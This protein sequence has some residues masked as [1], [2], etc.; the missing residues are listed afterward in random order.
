MEKCA[1][2]IS[3]Y[4]WPEALELCLK[5]VIQQTILPDE[6]LIADDGSTDSTK[7][8][9]ESFV[10]LGIVN[11]K[12]VWHE[13]VGFRKTIILNKAISMI[14]SDY[15]IQIDGDVILDRNFIK[16]HLFVR[17]KGCFIRGTRAHIHKDSLKRLFKNKEISL[18]FYSRG[19]QNRFNALRVSFLAFLMIRKKMSGKNVRGCNLAYWKHDVLAINGY[20]NA[21][22]GWGHEDEELALRFV[23]FGL[24]KKSVKLRCVQYHIYHPLS[25]RGNEHEHDQELVRVR[26]DKLV[27]CESG[28]REL[29][30]N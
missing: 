1:L 9:I 8:V 15:I 11:V 22:T 20:N 17:E 2:L 16:D 6:V 14:E 26:K 25:S 10:N 27:C 21:L 23:N 3:T 18:K 24:L 7:D 19:I 30:S 12:H 29:S 4:N 28:I 5:S 13:D